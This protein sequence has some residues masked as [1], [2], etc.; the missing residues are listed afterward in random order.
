MSE[1]E[2]KKHTK[3]GTII[4]GKQKP[5]N[6]GLRKRSDDRIILENSYSF[7]SDTKIVTPEEALSIKIK[8]KEKK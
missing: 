8:Q 2:T 4:P 6:N 5:V 3:E 1:K 7:P